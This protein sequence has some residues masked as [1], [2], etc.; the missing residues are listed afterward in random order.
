MT[1]LPRHAL[2]A[3]LATMLITGSG[4]MVEASA[5]AIA[6]DPSGE[7]KSASIS[8]GQ[9]AV[10]DVVIASFDTSWL[11]PHQS[12]LSSPPGGDG[13]QDS[14]PTLDLGFGF[15][16]GANF[17]VFGPF[18]FAQFTLPGSGPA[19]GKG[20]GGP[21]GH[22][23]S[24]KQNTSAQGGGKGDQDDGDGGVVVTTTNPGDQDDGDG[25]VVVTEGNSD[26]SGGSGITVN[27]VPEPAGLSLF[28]I[29]LLGLG[30]L[31]RRR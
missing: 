15:G 27:Q 9:Y 22:D 20:S 17:G 31:R 23:N 11:N 7:H 21:Q 5:G 25:D 16:I 3:V 30:A 24:T 10:G 26:G 28:G 4:A 18:G 12:G 2:D 29:G 1:R 6:Y 8:D 13:H 14:P 19:G